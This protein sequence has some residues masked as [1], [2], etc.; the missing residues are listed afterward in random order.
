MSLF[1]KSI[2]GGQPST[3]TPIPPPCDSPKVVTRKSWP[4]LLPMSHCSTGILPVGPTGVSPVVQKDIDIP[5]RAADRHSVRCQQ[6]SGPLGTQVECLCSDFCSARNSTG[7][8]PV[9]PTAGTAVPRIKSLRK[10]TGDRQ[11]DRARLRRR[12]LIAPVNR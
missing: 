11:S 8:T 7:E 10:R 1:D 4:K 2:R 6:V 3:T 12:H 5:V 9:G